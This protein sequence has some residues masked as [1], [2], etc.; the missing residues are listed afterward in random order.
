MMVPI[1]LMLKQLASAY[2]KSIRMTECFIIVA[3]Q[4]DYIDLPYYSA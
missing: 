3:V 1:M 4:L 2:T